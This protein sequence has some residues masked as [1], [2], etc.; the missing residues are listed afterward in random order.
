[1][2]D[3]P[4]PF[5]T[6]G[7]DG[8]SDETIRRFLLGTLSASEQLLFEQRLMSDAVLDARVR[9]LELDL[10]DDYAC[11]RLITADRKLFEERFLV[12]RD[13]QR[14]LSVSE[15]LR[16][17]FSLSGARKPAAR[18][19]T[20][21][22][23]K[24]VWHFFG[25]DRPAWRI[26]FSALILLMLFGT[27]LL[28]VKEPRL[29]ERITNRIIPRRSTPRSAPREVNHPTN[30]SSPEHSSTP[31][32][33]PPHESATQPT[34]TVALFPTAPAAGRMPAVILTQG[35]RDVVRLKLVVTVDQTAPYRVEVM[36][37]GG[38]TVMVV[39]RLQGPPFEVDLAMR[40]LKRGPYQLR[41]SDARDPS[42]KAVASYYFL[43]Q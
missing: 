1:M 34:Q 20:G 16:D 25:L 2:T 8:S 26:A 15:L 14:R 17:R 13:R 42:K 11:G 7:S 37:I 24:W 9:L 35:E 22:D 32:P 39:D 21:W 4:N 19:E 38:E 30:T 10:A 6:S 3:L 40:A 12:T 43:V 5:K 28:V 27:V 31:S 23:A 36:T 33:L 18:P 29:A 41:L